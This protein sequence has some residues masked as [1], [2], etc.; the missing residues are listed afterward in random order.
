MRVGQAGIRACPTLGW[1]LASRKSRYFVAFYVGDDEVILRGGK[2][3]VALRTD[4]VDRIEN[5]L[6][7][8]YSSILPI[9]RFFEVIR[10]NTQTCLFKD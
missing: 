6:H 9:R 5:N 8:A 7:K 3:R 2:E 10:K 1:Q 4:A